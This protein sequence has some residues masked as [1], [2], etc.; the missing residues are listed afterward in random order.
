ML[1][2]R[3]EILMNRDKKYPL[4]QELERNLHNLLIALNK[5]QKIYEKPMIVNSGYR[6][7]EFNEIANGAKKS[8]HTLCLA[9]DFQDLDGKLD[10]FCVENQN[11]LKNLGLFLEH[12]KWTKK[13]CHLQIAK[14]KSG[15]LIFIPSNCEPTIDKIDNDFL[16]LYESNN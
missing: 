14:P 6:P 3:E 4:S 5:F 16:S 1:I 11:V 10:K 12:P 7:A 8:N 2:T 9:C 15:N 13:W